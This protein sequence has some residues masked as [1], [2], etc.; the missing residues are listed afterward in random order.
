[1]CWFFETA[2]SFY[3]F[4]FSPF[5][6]QI[7]GVYSG[8]LVVYGASVLQTDSHHFSPTTTFNP[9]AIVSCLWHQAALDGHSQRDC[10]CDIKLSHKDFASQ[11]Y[12]N[13]I[14]TLGFCSFLTDNFLVWNL[15]WKRNKEIGRRADKKKKG[16]IQEPGSRACP[17]TSATNDLAAG[18]SREENPAPPSRHRERTVDKW[19]RDEAGPPWE[20]RRTPDSEV[21]ERP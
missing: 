13:L 6:T 15:F 4:Y 1:M 12:K 2:A 10:S 7:W 19:P 11:F 20:G 17:V 3:F 18:A 16:S 21:Q 14:K 9:E 8:T 5:L